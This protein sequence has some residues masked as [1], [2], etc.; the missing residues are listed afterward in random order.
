MNRYEKAQKDLSEA[1]DPNSTMSSSERRRVVR[2]SKETI[3]EVEKKL[4]SSTKVME[5]NI[6]KL[7]KMLK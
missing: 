6:D 5:R 2:E 4:K 3:E 1:K 7:N